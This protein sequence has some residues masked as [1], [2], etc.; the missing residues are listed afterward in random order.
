[1]KQLQ[2]CCELRLWAF[3]KEKQH[4]IAGYGFN[5]SLAASSSSGLLLPFGGQGTFG[6]RLRK[7]ALI[8]IPGVAGKD[9][10]VKDEVCAP[11]VDEDFWWQGRPFC[12]VD[13]GGV[14]GQYSGTSHL[15]EPRCIRVGRSAAPASG[16]ERRGLRL[17]ATAPSWG[18]PSLFSFPDL[19]SLRTCHRQSCS[20]CRA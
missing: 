11:A 5:G 17:R 3:S 4:K 6:V 12:V 7:R 15:G 19:S 13:V 20:R 10:V 14:A 16:P 8:R 9:G 18:R 2:P 1:M